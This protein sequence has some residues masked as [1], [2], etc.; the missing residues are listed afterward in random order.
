MMLTMIV[1][2]F[3]PAGTFDYWQ[4]WVF[5]GLFFS[6]SFIITLYLLKKDPALLER[7]MKA[8]N[9]DSEKEGK[10]KIIQFLARVAFVGVLVVC[11]FDYRY[12]G[13]RVPLL[14]VLFGECLVF[15][16]LLNTF[17]VF[18]ENTFASS[19]IE[20]S[21]GQKVISTGP[22][23]LVRHPMYS[24][25][26][27]MMFGLPLALGSWWGLL[28]FFPILGVLVWRLLEEEKFL[29]KNL[30]GYPEY[31]RKVKFRLFPNLW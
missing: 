27:V 10:Q 8:A 1:F 11:G 3:L 17:L 19:I 20:I 9:L 7:R 23:S 12:S 28:S 13:A 26:L 5:L 14:G 22:Y 29:D 21:S 4:G 2:L 16:G 31:R 25:A 6:I 18:R 24:G 30:P 15:L